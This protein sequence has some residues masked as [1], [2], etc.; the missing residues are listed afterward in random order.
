MPVKQHTTTILHFS[1]LF[2]LFSLSA[3]TTL[4]PL[5]PSLAVF[6]SIHTLPCVISLIIASSLKECTQ[7]IFSTSLTLVTLITLVVTLHF[8]SLFFSSCE[9]N[10]NLSRAPKCFNNLAH[11]PEPIVRSQDT[12]Y[13]I[14]YTHNPHSLD[15]IPA[16]LSNILGRS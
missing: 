16:D 7:Q 13:S 15:H 14:L 5:S 8:A 11:T 10:K 6:T 2:S 9:C 1:P 12:W 3:L 4:S